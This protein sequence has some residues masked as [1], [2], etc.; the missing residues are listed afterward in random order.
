MK[1]IVLS[2]I[3]AVFAVSSLAAGDKAAAKKCV[4]SAS[5]KKGADVK[6]CN[7][8]KKAEKKD[9]LKKAD[10]DFKTAK[11]ACAA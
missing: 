7:K 11:A 5:G 10:E 1:K 8:M 3:L 6:A 4:A 2:A 9:C